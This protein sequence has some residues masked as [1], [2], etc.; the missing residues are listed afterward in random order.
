MRLGEALAACPELVVLEQDPAAVEEEWERRLEEAGLAVEPV[1]PGCVYFET[2]GVERLA[3]SLDAVLRRALASAGTEWEPR[4]GAAS[5]RFT[6]LA[7]ASVAPTG[8]AIVVD[9]GEA[10]LFL[11]PLPLDLLPLTPDRRR[12]LSELGI[13][14]L[15]E[16][17]RLPGASVAD[18]L[19][20]D[21]VEA[22]Q[23]ARGRDSMGVFPRKPPHELAEALAFPEAVGNT[24]TLDRALAGLLERLLARPERAGRAL[25]QLALSA[26]LV[27]GGSWRRRVTLREP[28]AD[29]VRLR[30]ALAPKL[31]ELPAPALE[32]RLAALALAEAAGTQEELVRPRGSSLRELLREG[33]RQARAA[34]GMDAVCT[35]VEVAPWSRIPETRALLVPRDD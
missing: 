13:R 31:A 16:L 14:R 1:E 10:D 18:R 28:T 30:T 7:A 4:I 35:V 20:P 11:E 17:A 5:R 24:F 25:R 21:G 8:R 19:G 34:A 22:W 23:L 29:P 33:L 27:G 6:A 3:G 26:R 15:G 32:L 12:E 9:D 2:G